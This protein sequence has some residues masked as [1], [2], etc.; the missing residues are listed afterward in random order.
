MWFGSVLSF[1]FSTLEEQHNFINV[2]NSKPV[3]KTFTSTPASKLKDS[4]YDRNHWQQTILKSLT[5][6][7]E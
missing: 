2:N 3:G 7:V 5:K 6:I 4:D 1:I